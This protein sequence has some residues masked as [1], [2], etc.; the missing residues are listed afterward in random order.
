MPLSDQKTKREQENK[1]KR[2]ATTNAEKKKEQR[3][4]FGMVHC[5]GLHCKNQQKC[6]SF[7]KRGSFLFNPFIIISL[8][9]FL[10]FLSVFLCLFLCYCNMFG[11]ELGYF[12]MAVLPAFL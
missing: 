4:R 10:L 3:K 8:F 12:Y 2:G 5:V 11:V 1:A 9:F 6:M 7:R